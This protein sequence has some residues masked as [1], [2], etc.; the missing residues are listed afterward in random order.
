MGRPLNQKAWK[1]PIFMVNFKD[2]SQKGRSH[3]PIPLTVMILPGVKKTRHSYNDQCT[4]M[5]NISQVK[6]RFGNISKNYTI[7]KWMY[8][9]QKW[10]GFVVLL[11]R[12]NKGLRFRYIFWQNGWQLHHEDWQDDSSERYLL[13]F[14]NFPI[15]LE[16]LWK[17]N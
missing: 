7:F 9:S 15:L 14:W 16:L 17:S 2:F 6:S 13:E 8:R 11:I 1:S 3:S 4:M 12:W 5:N 10:S